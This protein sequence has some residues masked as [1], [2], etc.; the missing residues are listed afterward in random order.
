MFAKLKGYFRV[1]TS[2]QIMTTSFHRWFWTVDLLV[3]GSW[4]CRVARLVYGHWLWYYHSG[5]NYSAKNTDYFLHRQILVSCEGKS[6]TNLVVVLTIEIGI[7]LLNVFF[8]GNVKYKRKTIVKLFGENIQFGRV[9]IASF[10]FILVV[11]YLAKF[12]T[13]S[14][15]SLHSGKPFLLWL[16]FF[17]NCYQPFCK[18]L[19][20]HPRPF[21]Q[22]AKIYLKMS[23][24]QAVD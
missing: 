9:W 5:D 4:R 19:S 17:K 13:L 15:L 12:C 11:T 18:H 24:Y 14:I 23:I 22:S 10:F 20:E 3:V 7:H 1:V 8:G 21:L 16:L 2:A 6:W